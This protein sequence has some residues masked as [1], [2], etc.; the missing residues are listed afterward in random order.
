MWFVATAANATV[1]AA[2]APGSNATKRG[3][4][5]VDG[6]GGWVGGSTGS[7]EDGSIEDGSIEDGSI[8]DESI[9]AGS[10]A[11][12]QQGAGTAAT[13]LGLRLRP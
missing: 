7:I 6:I 9:E 8:E 2:L 10:S 12:G 4:T 13:E 11:E 5:S 3:D 1:L